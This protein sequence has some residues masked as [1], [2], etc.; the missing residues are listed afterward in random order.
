MTRHDDTVRLRHMLDH[1]EEAVEMCRQHNRQD[2]DT[3]RQ[4]SLALTH[5]V[6]IVGEAAARISPQGRERWATIPWAGVVGLRNRLIHG[7]DE[8]DLNI[9]WD[10]IRQDLP[11]LTKEL[12]KILGGAS[13]QRKEDGG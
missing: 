10:I 1:A 7:Y 3:D 11:T 9:L 13:G 4:L 2:L 8:V 5:L 6:V 12:K